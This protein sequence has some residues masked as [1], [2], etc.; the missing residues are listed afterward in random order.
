[1]PL[2]YLDFVTKVNNGNGYTDEEK[3]FIKEFAPKLDNVART[4]VNSEDDQLRQ[5]GS[6]L[7]TVSSF[8]NSTTNIDANAAMENLSAD[9]DNNTAIINDTAN[10]L[11]DPAVMNQVLLVADYDLGDSGADLYK[12]FDITKNRMEFDYKLEDP[13]DEM[14]RQFQQ[15]MDQLDQEYEDMRQNLG[16]DE[17]INNEEINAE[18]F[19]EEELIQQMQNNV[20]IINQAEENLQ[21]LQEEEQQ[22]DIDRANGLADENGVAYPQGSYA[23]WGAKLKTGSA[24]SEQDRALMQKMNNNS[25]AL[26]N[27]I[28]ASGNREFAIKLGNV[29]RLTNTMASPSYTEDMDYVMDPEA[30]Y[31]DDKENVQGIT[32]YF[33]SYKNI[34]SLN[35]ALEP[36]EEGD[37]IIEKAEFVRWMEIVSDV[38]GINI[39]L[40]KTKPAVQSEFGMQI[41]TSDLFEPGDYHETADER[42]QNME[43]NYRQNMRYTNQRVPKLE[44]TFG[45]N[46]KIEGSDE[47][48]D[49]FTK[50]AADEYNA[51]TLNAPQSLGEHGKTVVILTQL[52]ALYDR[53]RNNLDAPLTSSNKSGNTS[54]Y[55]FNTTFIMEN[56]P[57]N[58]DRERGFSDIMANSRKRAHDA[59]ENYDQD[60]T[61]VINCVQNM[62]KYTKESFLDVDPTGAPQ[63]A[64]K[65]LFAMEAEIIGDPELSK[66]FG[67]DNILTEADKQRIRA[68]AVMIKG[69]A[70]FNDA[71]ARLTTPEDLEKIESAGYYIKDQYVKNAIFG[72]CVINS[73]YDSVEANPIVNN[74][75]RSKLNKYSKYMGGATDAQAEGY[76]MDKA[77]KI[78]NGSPVRTKYYGLGQGIRT[79]LMGV[80][81]PREYLSADNLA[82]G[83]P[84]GEKKLKDDLMSKVEE[85]KIYKQMMKC[86][87]AVEMRRFTEKLENTKF[88]NLGVVVDPQ[89]KTKFMEQ[90]HEINDLYKEFDNGLEDAFC[91]DMTLEIL[92]E[93]ERD[94]NTSRI[95]HK[96]SAE[97]NKLKEKMAELREITENAEDSMDLAQSQEYKNKLL[98]VY[99][100][101]VDYQDKNRDKHGI[102]YNDDVTTPF[103]FLGGPRFAGA[104]KL[105][106]FAEEHH[107]VAEDVKQKKELRAEKEAQ[108][109]ASVSGIRNLMNSAEYKNMNNQQKIDALAPHIVNILTTDLFST[110][111]SKENVAGKPRL[112]RDEFK[113]S[114][115]LANQQLANRKEVKAV[116]NDK[117]MDPDKLAALATSK[118]GRG[119]IG[120]VAKA[121]AKLKTTAQAN[122]NGPRRT[123]QNKG[124]KL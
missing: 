74:T 119:L 92:D 32:E 79:D 117:D 67:V 29:M 8:A 48:E 87:D 35:T 63:N 16:N 86:K 82:L 77:F 20:N 1:M 90:A 93:A 17:E 109:Q 75:L 71:A 55:D 21:Q 38:M 96:N 41:D 6:Q 64:N 50:K 100:A 52:G 22:L 3:Q 40:K 103:S 36:D 97:Y 45:P 91:K 51:I 108:Y 28:A 4:L 44:N 106:K 59:L 70:T 81:Y 99:Q 78:V 9:W 27:R 58:D 110:D 13:Q 65:E 24:M 95:G 112:S 7:I 111:L 46:G 61:E 19:T 116:L 80:A 57:D 123:V 42:P 2:N 101:S 120:E 10:K 107:Y 14:I 73:R 118:H 124:P 25:A 33:D 105:E 60:P 83:E 37:V 47:N 89:K 76:M 31:D 18:G 68:N 34:Q 72:A 12:F 54:L 23:Q 121:D 5:L 88:A 62:F 113:A 122:N 53:Q 30:A 104:K 49:V 66:K 39:N 85:T 94:L 26:A 11:N 115:P 102:A 69:N 98:E 114:L 84:D 43:T 15:R 56:I